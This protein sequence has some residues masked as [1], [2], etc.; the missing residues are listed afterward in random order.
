MPLLATLPLDVLARILTLTADYN[1]LRAAALSCKG[2]YAAYEAYP[3]GINKSVA[4]NLLPA[5]VLAP[6]LRA[7]RVGDELA[8]IST[9]DNV[10]DIMHKHDEVRV[11]DTL[12]TSTECTALQS[13]ACVV[14][15]IEVMFSRTF[16]DRTSVSSSRLSAGESEL[17]Q[18]A[19]HRIWL[20]TQV[21]RHCYV[22]FP[23]EVGRDEV[24]DFEWRKDLLYA[25]LSS[26]D[27]W[28]IE[29]VLRWLYVACED[30]KAFVDPDYVPIIVQVGPDG[31]INLFD[32]EP[33]EVDEVIP[34]I[35]E[36]LGF[37]WEEDIRAV[38][39]ERKFE[40]PGG[41]S[42]PESAPKGLNPLLQTVFGK[43]D[44]CASCSSKIGLALLNQTNW[45]YNKW[46][47]SFDRLQYLLPHNL[48]SN[49]HERRTLT[50]Y[51][52][53]PLQHMTKPTPTA[54][55][56]S[57]ISTLRV[58]RELFDLP[59]V[60]TS[61]RLQAHMLADGFSSMTPHDWLCPTCL[62]EFI[63]RHLWIWWWNEKARGRVLGEPLRED[64][65]YGYECRT[66]THNFSHAQ[67]LNHLCVNTNEERLAAKKAGTAQGNAGGP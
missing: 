21:I 13:R 47:R 44:M 67:K 48:V 45:E 37:E 4:F 53:H 33:S 8:S 7:I 39:E 59:N 14:A 36:P 2:L 31:F 18:K 20:F 41:V 62:V 32:K 5:A 58:L 51:F 52:K 55:T 30:L 1:T 54:D 65:W 26:Q 46:L 38:L 61:P 23:D 56:G 3:I 9:S 64:C 42:R 28:E 11:F 25:N 16:K 35:D 49:T 12:L 22:D 60:V 40:V 34:D 57:P 63:T 10:E 29:T 27:L 24:A 50:A 17:F 19:L 15:R 6:A 43:D 66:Q